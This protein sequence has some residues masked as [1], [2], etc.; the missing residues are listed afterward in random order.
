[1]HN[2][3]GTSGLLSREGAPRPHEEGNTL[4][5][6]PGLPAC[7]SVCL[8]LSVNVPISIYVYTYIYISIDPPVFRSAYLPTYRPTNLPTYRPTC[9]STCR[10]REPI[11]SQPIPTSALPT[12]RPAA[13]VCV[14][15]STYRPT[16]LPPCLP[17]IFIH[18]SVL[19][20][21]LPA[22]THLRFYRIGLPVS[23]PIC[24]SVCPSSLVRS[25]LP[26]CYLCIQICT[27][28]L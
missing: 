11:C 26:M 12:Y 5:C 3:R 27:Q 24:L 6:L 19:S 21:H 7:L 17:T 22:S 23:R 18:L 9:L 4:V 1:M 28:R 16:Y 14:S 15:L 13:S 10:T 2:L 8:S 20:I 25:V